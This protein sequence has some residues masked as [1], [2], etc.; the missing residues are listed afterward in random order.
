[1]ATNSTHEGSTPWPSHVSKAPSQTSILMLEVVISSPE[2]GAYI[3][4]LPLHSR[5]PLAMARESPVGFSK[6][7]G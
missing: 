4:I 2:F 1:M 7:Q 6:A 3:H 5:R